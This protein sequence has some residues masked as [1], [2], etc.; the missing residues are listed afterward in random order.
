MFSNPSILLTS[1]GN[2]S[3][4]VKCFSTY[5]YNVSFTNVDL[6]LPETPLTTTKEP[7]GISTLTLFKLWHLA[8]LILMNLPV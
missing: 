8:P 3:L 4:L 6:P 2:V 5:L 7:N 1:P